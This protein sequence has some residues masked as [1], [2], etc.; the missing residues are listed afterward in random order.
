[1]KR[2]GV[3]CLAGVLVLVLA[4]AAPSIPVARTVAER[5][6][7]RDPRPSLGGATGR[8]RATSPP[9]GRRRRA[10]WPRAFSCPKP[11]RT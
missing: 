11:P 8:T 10:R 9:S 4:G 6:A 1:M 7:A 2:L 5:Q 3:T